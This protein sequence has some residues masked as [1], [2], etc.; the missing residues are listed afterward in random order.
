MKATTPKGLLI[1]RNKVNALKMEDVGN[2]TSL[3]V[4]ILESE[5]KAFKRN[6]P[7]TYLPPT[8]SHPPI[9]A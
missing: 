8:L 3:N 9:P 5:R 7:V 1:G 2:G 6:Y 4:C